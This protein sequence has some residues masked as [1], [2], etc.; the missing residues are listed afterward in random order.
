VASS[1]SNTRTL[2]YE[3][4]VARIGGTGC[5]VQH[6]S[7]VHAL[8][9]DWSAVITRLN[10]YENLLSFVAVWCE[11]LFKDGLANSRQA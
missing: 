6:V 10:T 4:G 9:R 5:L 3:L 7:T 11:V 2:V 1:L 8:R